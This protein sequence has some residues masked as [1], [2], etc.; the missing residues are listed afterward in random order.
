VA[1]IAAAPRACQRLGAQRR[2]ARSARIGGRRRARAWHAASTRGS[3]R[4]GIETTAARRSRE[5]PHASQA[6]F[7]T[8]AF[9]E[10]K[11]LPTL[12]PVV[13]RRQARPRDAT[14]PLINSRISM[15]KTAVLALLAGASALAHA[16]SNVTLFGVLDV[17]ARYTKNGDD[18][19]KSLASNGAQSSRLGLRGVEDLGDGLKAGF[20]LEAGL[21][22][23]T[24]T[25]S[26]STRF[27]NRRST[28]S[29][30]GRFGEVRL[31]RDLTPTYTGYGDYDVF[32]TNGVAAADKFLTA[33]GTNADT[34]VRADNQVSYFLPSQLGG[35]YGQ[36]SIAPGEGT[37]GKKYAGGRIGYT[38][39]ALDLSLSYGQTKVTALAGTS[40]DSY[41]V[42]SVGASYD[43]RVVKLLGYVTQAKYADHKLTIANLGASVPVGPGTVRLS[44][45]HADASGRT[46][47]GASTEG[48]DADQLALG[49][50]YDLSKRTS[51]YSTVA[52]VN[53][54]KAAAYVVDAKPALPS[55][56]TGR[57][58]TGFE[59]GIRHRF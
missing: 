21:N 28:V 52:R 34:R 30:I 13:S 41:K 38:T 20:W 51:L 3:V 46:P 36:L 14:H 25:T 1:T 9:R 58:S 45:I 12:H 17:A 39:G 16:Q 22:P 33:L 5:V 15:K 43:F 53:N 32:G 2:I 18:N 54:D 40:E 4:G 23:D 6:L 26:D 27:W 59:V 44:Y 55:P 57:D 8:P 29:L 37:A 35:V 48:D 42:G 24:G 19:V 50:V 31:G 7:G 11:P 49:Y 56:N 10:R 47:A